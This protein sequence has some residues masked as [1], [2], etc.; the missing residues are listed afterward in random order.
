MMRNFGFVDYD[1]VRYIGTNGKM[2]EVAAAM[3]LTS[4]ESIA[5]FIE[6][7]RRNYHLYRGL[8]SGLPG[9]TLLPYDESERCNYQYIVLEIDGD[10]A[11]GLSRDLLQRVL[12][13]ENVLVRRYFYPGCHR[14]EPYRSSNPRGPA[15]APADRASGPAGSAAADRDRASRQDDIATICDVIRFA[16]TRAAEIG[17][18]QRS[19]SG[20]PAARSWV[21][22]EDVLP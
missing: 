13:G 20:P 8:L 12:H 3:G 7:N 9:V 22:V 14:M 4:L 6:A 1:D 10:S 19:P 17:V 21:E 16:V 15:D 2:A 11:A 18:R 5:E